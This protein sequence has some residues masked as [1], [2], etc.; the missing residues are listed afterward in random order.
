MDIKLPKQW[1]H[2]CKKA[3]LRPYY[4]KGRRW[5]EWFY[6]KGHGR[7]WRVNCSDMLGCGDTHKEFNRWVLCRSEVTPRP[8]NEVEFIAAVQE[9][10][11]KQ[12]CK[13]AHC[14]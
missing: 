10:L 14:T 9:L 13:S 4:G 1:R 7:V 6:L 3:G 5:Y 12:N 8:N 11:Y 2:W